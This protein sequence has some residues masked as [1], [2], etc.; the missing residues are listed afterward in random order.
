M[1]YRIELGEIENAA[2][3]LEHMKRVCC[4]YDKK[5]QVI[6]LL[7]E[8]Q[9]SQELVKESMKSKVPE[10]MVPGRV[11]QL[12]EMPMNANGKIDRRLLGEKYL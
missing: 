10:Y 11:V 12:E 7:Y 8:G 2:M 9:L 6:I 3:T 4:L 5:R 1:G